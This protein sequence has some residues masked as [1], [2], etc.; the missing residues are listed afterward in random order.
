MDIKSLT[1][2]M[3]VTGIVPTEA[4]EIVAAKPS[5][6][7]VSVVFQKLDGSYDSVVLFSEDLDKVTEVAGDGVRRFDGDASSFLLASEALRIR[8]SYAFDNRLAMHTSLIE[9]LPH[10]I[11]AVYED[12]LP[13]QPLRFLL[14]DDPGAGKTIMA[15][16]LIKELMIRGEVERCLIVC[17][18]GGYENLAFSSEGVKTAQRL[19]EGGYKA[20][21]LNYRYSP[22][23]W[24]KPQEDLA[25]AILH[26][27]AN[28]KEYGIDP[29]NLM[30]LGYSAGGHL[31][32]S[33]AALRTEIAE[34][35][36]AD[37][38]EMRPD[39]CE[40]YRDISVRPDKVCLC[41][42]VISFL[43]NQHEPS[44]QA[45]T[46]GDETLR[47][48]LSI[49]KQVDGTYPKTFIW[50]C[51]DDSLVPPDNA[52]RMGKALSDAG[53]ESRLIV[54]PQGEH[55]CSIGIGTSAEGWIDEM[56]EFM[57]M[58]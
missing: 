40:K 26:V 45:L 21:I 19:I 55:G 48:H 5:N 24:P 37:L 27:R 38:A 33:T 23:R 20:F 28:A 7:S 6:D 53:I 3:H 17:P 18:G 44:F 1:P 15:G 58:K 39:L 8:Y 57:N 49:E 47:E 16:L 43:S 12:M 54:Y 2:G 41:Y 56:L 34:A 30:I 4:V 50:T 25:L 10:Q 52:E 29:D 14:A 46:G 11:T 42:P 22:N 35:L 31:C 32:A 51:A 36:F 9:P 13:R